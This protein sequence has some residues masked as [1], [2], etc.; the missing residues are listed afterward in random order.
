MRDRINNRTANISNMTKYEIYYKVSERQKSVNLT[1]KLQD[2]I[3][4][5]IVTPVVEKN[6]SCPKGTEQEY[7]SFVES[8]AS[9]IVSDLVKKIGRI[10]PEVA[11]NIMED[12]GEVAT[13]DSDA[14]LTFAKFYEKTHK[15]I[16][17]LYCWAPSTIHMYYTK[18]TKNIA[19]RL[20]NKPM[21]LLTEEDYLGAIA[22][23]KKEKPDVKQ[24]TIDQYKTNLS[25]VI[26]YA[27][28]CGVCSENP[29]GKQK[30]LDPLKNAIDER[31]KR[32]SMNSSEMNTVTTL[33]IEDF[34]KSN[35]ALGT[36]FMMFL[37]L[38]TAEACGP[39]YRDI[40]YF[41]DE[42]GRCYLASYTQNRS[43]SEKGYN[44]YTS[45]KKTVNG[46][47][48]IP[49]PKQLQILIERKRHVLK[50][51]GFTEAEIDAMPIVSAGVSGRAKN[52][53]ATKKIAAAKRCNSIELGKYGG[54]KLSSVL[55]SNSHV[56]IPMEEKGVDGGHNDS[57]TLWEKIESDSQA[58]VLR[59]NFAT[60]MFGICGLTTGQVQYLMGHK[61]ENDKNNSALEFTNE[62]EL[63]K[64]QKKM[65]RLIFINSEDLQEKTNSWSGLHSRDPRDFVQEITVPKEEVINM[66]IDD[67]VG[68]RLRIEPD[69]EKT[70]AEI[71]LVVEASE[72]SGVLGYELQSDGCIT[73][74]VTATDAI[75]RS[76]PATA[77]VLSYYYDS[78]FSKESA[79]STNE[80]SLVIES[81]SEML[82]ESDDCQN[83]F[84][85]L[86][87]QIRD[88]ENNIDKAVDEPD[89]ADEGENEGDIDDE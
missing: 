6:K 4:G 59:R 17:R 61:Q 47:R 65:D 48:Y 5:R 18:I 70:S 69:S 46:Y 77:N 13:D 60:N 25:S 15:N 54:E 30:S 35:L 12:Y 89:D 71:T 28:L 49:I 83:L 43:Y 31:Q 78:V 9:D 20:S 19:P 79:D 74:M 39:N 63:R 21:Y 7:K 64:I 53:E 88:Y 86:E 45:R 1:C 52:A 33:L 75:G 29:F 36:A 73:Y 84:E 57:E 24:S 85:E 10:A 2:K 22:D 32:K 8:K 58:Y 38:R 11:A 80:K 51:M 40:Q 16:E 82:N 23:I 14:L 41:A 66:E 42:P 55:K 37:G 76:L 67:E 72:P 26:H 87:D 56:E 68:C 62:D 44:K 27:V 3:T 81:Q 50:K 34:E